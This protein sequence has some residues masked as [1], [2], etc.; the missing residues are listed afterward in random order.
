MMKNIII[1]SLIMATS[2]CSF[3]QNVQVYDWEN[4]AVISINKEDPHATLIPYNTV[5]QAAPGDPSESPYYKL[6]NGDWKFKWVYKYK[7]RNT[8]FLYATGYE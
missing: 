7:R 6:L 2:L 1:L 3:A 4:P 8:W 5:E